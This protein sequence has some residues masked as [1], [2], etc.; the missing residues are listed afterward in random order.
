VT[1]SV[2]SE[3][4][5]DAADGGG[6]LRRFSLRTKLLL[7]AACLVLAPGALYGAIAVSRS[8]AALARSVGRELAGEARNAAD[9]LA[10]ALR[11]ERDDLASF[12]GQDVMREIRI[13][14]L[15]KRIASFLRSVYTGCPTCVDLSVIDATG[16]VVAATDAAAI[17]RASDPPAGEAAAPVIEGPLR[18][19]A[20]GPTTLR[21]RVPIRDPDDV[22]R[23]LG[24][25]MARLDW[26][27]LG[28]PT[29]ETR[30]NLAAA[31]I[32][33]DVLVLDAAGVVIGGAPRGD[34]RW[35]RG[36]TVGFAAMTPG[37][38]ADGAGGIAAD[39]RVAYGR[40]ELPADLPRW[41]IVV[42]Q[43]LAEALAPVH[44]MARLL[45]GVLAATLVAALAV[46]IAAGRRIT[47][48]LAELTAAARRVGRGDRP[49]PVVT[50]RSTDEIGTLATAFNRMAD[51]LRQAERRLVDAAKFAFVGELAAGVAHEVRTPLGVLR[52]SAQLL[53]RS[54]PAP[55]VYPEG[56]AHPEGDDEVREL[57][58]IVR[59]EVD[60]IERVVSG[61]LE[62][63][64]P[65]EM[66]REPARLGGIVFRA[67]DFVDVQAR[68]RG[69]T[70][71]RIPVAADPVVSCD[72]ELIYQV[73]L[74]LLV[75]AVQIVPASGRIELALVPAANGRAAFEVRD[76]GPGIP[77]DLREAVF[78]PFFTRREGGAGLGLT[79]VQR[80][81]LEHGGRVSVRD[82][83]GRG[84]VFRVE[85]ET[86]A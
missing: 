74:N 18:D 83:G 17:G 68:A 53:E 60:R 13:G 58:H 7:F 73:A 59:D 77:E 61:L 57:L 62:L 21:F 11:S 6:T 75:N 67:A 9:R 39:D 28:A 35:R 16:R 37:S 50:V 15:D 44:R 33:A 41:T 40:A 76:D 2:P 22:T 80:V 23:R 85:L 79:F 46:A 26:E 38:Q 25:L 66:A 71:T 27:R 8:R 36:D 56:A 20:G 14:D 69:L 47:R 34:E 63:G 72:P 65:R 78:Q 1:T 32:D 49:P 55:A 64:R 86:V 31:G 70:I 51:D 19:A 12:A 52:S 45:A 29:V 43:P 4:N 81:V 48:P 24:W 3:S 84:C 54:L 5:R 42:A 10:T 82:N 30:R